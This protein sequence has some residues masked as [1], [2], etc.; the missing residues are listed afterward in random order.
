[1]TQYIVVCV[2]ALGASALTLFSGFGLGTLLLPAFLVFFDAPVAVAMTAVVHFANNLV[3]LGIVGRFADRT[4]VWRFGMLAIPASVVG[5]LILAT[6]SGRAPIVTYSL[7]GRAHHVTIIGVAV[8]GLIALFALWEVAPRLSRLSFAPRYLPIGGALSGFFG[9][10]SGHQGA[11]R[12]AFLIRS[13]LSKE[14]YVGTG[15]VIACMVDAARLALY[16]RNMG[17]AAVRDQ[18]SLVLAATLSAVAGAVLASRALP[19]VS[20][21]FVRRV[22]TAL[23]FAV[24]AAIAIGLT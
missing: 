19:A 16:G 10:L 17:F 14:A 21:H 20:M 1:M 22:T 11:L 7:F 4:V 8:G 18:W 3:K 6:L 2:V 24:A 5:A 9:G 13:G 15:V 12:S 23:L